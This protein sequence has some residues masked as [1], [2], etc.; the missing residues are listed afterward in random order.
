M[1]LSIRRCRAITFSPRC[2]ARDGLCHK[3]NHT[4]TRERNR[5]TRLSCITALQRGPMPLEYTTMITNGDY[6]H[7]D[8]IYS[9]RPPTPE[10]NCDDENEYANFCNTAKRNTSC[11]SGKHCAA[12]VFHANDNDKLGVCRRSKMTTL[13]TSKSSPPSPPARNDGRDIVQR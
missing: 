11:R 12:I 8:A 13:F 5:Y 9:R 6:L 10:I 4:T 1:T 2:C 3:F 7:I